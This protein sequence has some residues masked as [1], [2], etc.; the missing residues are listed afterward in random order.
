MHNSQ[1]FVRIYSS[2]CEIF[3][4]LHMSALNDCVLIILGRGKGYLSFT[5][6]AYF[7]KL[8]LECSIRIG[9]SGPTG[10]NKSYQQ[11]YFRQSFT[12]YM[13]N[14]ITSCLLFV[15]TWYPICQT[16]ILVNKINKLYTD[17]MHDLYNVYIL[18]IAQSPIQNSNTYNTVFNNSYSD[19]S[20]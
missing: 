17:K 6:L 4:Y 1:E 13:I 10:G 15:F 8:F 16:P 20:L 14:K 9:H 18:S 5:S 3:V 7:T 11:R 19:V 12:C 2:V